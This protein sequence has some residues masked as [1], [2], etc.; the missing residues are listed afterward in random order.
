M[1]RTVLILVSGLAA[2]GLAHFGWFES[3]RP[4]HGDQLT[5]QLDWIRSELHLTDAQYA[6]V[7]APFVDLASARVTNIKEY[8]R[9]AD[10]IATQR[11][12]SRFTPR[13]PGRAV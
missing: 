1:N 8:C 4:C 6:R 3:H 12:M 7:R 10:E 13:D 5:C 2:G 9:H 11:R